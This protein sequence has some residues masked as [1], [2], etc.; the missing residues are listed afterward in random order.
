M[1]AA[2]ELLSKL[3][4]LQYEGWKGIIDERFHNK[5]E[6]EIISLIKK[7][8]LKTT[9]YWKNKNFITDEIYFNED[10]KELLDK[11]QKHRNQ[12]MH[13][14]MLEPSNDIL[15]ESI[16]LMVRIINQLNWQDTLPMRD[17]YLS[18]SLKSLLGVN[19]Y[20]KL[21][22]NSCYV[23]EAIDRAYELYPDDVKHCVECANQSW[24]LNDEDSWVCI[25]CGNRSDVE[26]LG[27]TDCPICNAKGEIVFDTLNI[28]INESIRG[29]CCSC[30]EYV[31]VT[32][33]KKCSAIS[34]L[35]DTCKF[36]D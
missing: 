5:S 34:V 19:L 18:N 1:Q 31:E 23:S 12:I 32:K 4:V 33:C 36:C 26:A 27:F 29:K 7:G 15:N 28:G 9:A 2:L 13:L 35:P 22:N 14:G 3:F 10:D 11:F 25:V 20:K 21:L 6:T 8:Q 30:R 16:W 17:Q 24:V